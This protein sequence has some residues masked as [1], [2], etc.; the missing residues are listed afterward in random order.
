MR[1]ASDEVGRD[2][3]FRYRSF[4]DGNKWACSSNLLYSRQ[5]YRGDQMPLLLRGRSNWGRRCAQKGLKR[6]RHFEKT[7]GAA[8]TKEATSF[9]FFFFGGEKNE[10]KRN[11]ADDRGLQISEI[12]SRNRPSERETK[13]LS[14]LSSASSSL[15]AP[16]RAP[17]APSP[18]PS[19][20]L[21]QAQ[22]LLEEGAPAR[23]QAENQ[24]KRERGPNRRRRK[25]RRPHR[26]IHQSHHASQA[27][28][29][30]QPAAKVSGRVLRREQ[31]HRR[32]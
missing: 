22:V 7:G 4:R 27:A 16:L 14:I 21:V 30:G 2:E 25:T 9:F 1:F 32:V 17:S 10:M 6:G 8:G 12:A 29:G 31:E 23:E 20:R 24:R 13:T 15:V 18:F 5:R 11:A 19:S 3:G 28:Q 26:I